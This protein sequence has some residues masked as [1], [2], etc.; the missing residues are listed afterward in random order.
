[1][2][3]IRSPDW[4]LYKKLMFTGLRP[5]KNRRRSDDEKNRHHK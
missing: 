1:M 4:A 2:D 3:I 5:I